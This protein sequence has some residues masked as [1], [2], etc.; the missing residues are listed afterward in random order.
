MND[1]AEMAIYGNANE[2]LNNNHPL[3]PPPSPHSYRLPTVKFEDQL[4]SVANMSSSNVSAL[5]VW[6]STP[7]AGSMFHYKKP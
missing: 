5:C 1:N 7:A 3:L 2:L 4:C 6:Q